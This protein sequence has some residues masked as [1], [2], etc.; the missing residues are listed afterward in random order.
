MSE[1]YLSAPAF[2][3]DTMPN[4]DK[5]EHEFIS[6]GD[7]YLVFEKGR[8]DGVSYTSKRYSKAKSI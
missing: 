1:S 7:M 4:I 8:R 3:W 6:D 2:C 5:V